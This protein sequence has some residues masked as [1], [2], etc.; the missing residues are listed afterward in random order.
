MDSRRSDM[1][2]MASEC[3][4]R[5]DLG[6]YPAIRYPDGAVVGDRY[7]TASVSPVQNHTALAGA[8]VVGRHGGEHADYQ[9]DSVPALDA[10]VG[11]AERVGHLGGGGVRPG[12]YHHRALLEIRDQH[13]R[14]GDANRATVGGA[15]DAT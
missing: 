10:A 12:D 13:H 5:G 15:G 7:A 4:E 3:G 8:A 9:S 14:A 1:P 11:D 2:C 6:I